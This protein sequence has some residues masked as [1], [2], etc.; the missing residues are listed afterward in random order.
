LSGTIVTAS[1]G[2]IGTDMTQ[3]EQTQ[4]QQHKRQRVFLKKVGKKKSKTPAGSRTS[5]QS[6]SVTNYTAKSIESTLGERI[7]E[8]TGLERDPPPV[9]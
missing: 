1:E 8:K 5:L 2:S 4:A 7:R 6:Y 9:G 3:L